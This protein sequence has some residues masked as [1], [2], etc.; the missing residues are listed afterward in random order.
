MVR[1]FLSISFIII[2]LFNIVGYY[3]LFLL[4]R[5][6]IRNEINTLISE[7]ITAESLTVLS[8]S[9]SELKSLKWLKE[10]EFSYKGELYDVVKNEIGKNGKI[11]LYCFNDT[12]ERRLTAHFEKQLNRQIENDLSNQKN[13]QKL[14]NILLKDYCA[15]E[16]IKIIAEN[17]LEIKFFEYTPYF[18]SIQSDEL[19]PPPKGFC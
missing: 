4:K 8:F 14:N 17:V 10:D 19:V 2:F 18:V 9:S 5:N 3:P 13:E 1:R 6:L 16:N 11:Y 15:P 12:K 7:N